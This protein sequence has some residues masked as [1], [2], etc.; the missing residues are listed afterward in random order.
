MYQVDPKSHCLTGVSYRPSPNCDER[1]KA[2]EIDLV[3]VHGISLPPNQFGGPY[4]EQLFTN[5]LDPGVHPYF[6]DIAGLR[7]SAHVLIRRD[8]E[9]IQFVPFD[10]RAWHAGE[11]QFQS[12]SGCND[13]SIGIELEGA[14]DIAYEPEQYHQ[15]A[16]VLYALQQAYP[17]ITREHIVG[18]CD[19]APQRKTDPG[20]IFEWPKLFQLLD[21]QNT[22]EA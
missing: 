3:V 7:V 18:H 6:A 10:R 15:L 21:Q 19:I 2:D 13:F 16:A 20:P 1:P 14:D 12:R 4:I 8:G 11:S 5:C 17:A 22:G 9:I